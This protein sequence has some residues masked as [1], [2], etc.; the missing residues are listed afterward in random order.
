[1]YATA[2]FITVKFVWNKGFEQ[3]RQVR[4]GQKM[5]RAKRTTPKIQK[6]SGSHRRCELTIV[7]S[8][9]VVE[10]PYPKAIVS[11][12]FS[13]SPVCHWATK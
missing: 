2:I 12:G 13:P 8:S 10:I 11:K 9:S 6:V 5:Y 4:V 7:R 3:Q 1:M